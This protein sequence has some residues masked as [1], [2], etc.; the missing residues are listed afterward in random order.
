MDQRHKLIFEPR[1]FI[2]SSEHEPTIEPGR[3]VTI[4]EGSTGYHYASPYYTQEMADKHHTKHNTTP[5]QIKAAV[6]CSMFDCWGNFNHIAGDQRQ[7]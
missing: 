2:A 6:V 3:L 5:E 7:D 1:V 4:T